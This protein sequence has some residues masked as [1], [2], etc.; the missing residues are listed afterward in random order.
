MRSALRLSLCLL[1]AVPLAFAQ[2]A[3]KAPAKSAAKE[4]AE[5]TGR[6]VFGTIGVDRKPDGTAE[7]TALKG[8][9]LRLGEDGKHALAYDTELARVV[10]GWSG[11]FVTEMNL[12]SR[13]EYPSALGS[14]YFST[15]D[16]LA[17]LMVGE[18]AA[19]LSVRKGYGHLGAGHYR[20][21]NFQPKGDGVLTFAVPGSADR[22]TEAPRVVDS[23]EAQVIVRALSTETATG[24]T[25][26]LG[27]TKD[28]DRIG[29]RGP[30]RREA[31]DGWEVYRIP[32]GKQQVEVA[33]APVGA[34]RPTGWPEETGAKSYA[35]FSTKKVVVKG[36]LSTKAGEPYVTDRIKLPEDN[37][38]KAPMYVSGVDFFDDGRV[39]ICTFHGDVWIGSGLDA[40][41]EQVTWERF[42]TGLYHPL[43]LKVVQGVIHVT[44]R[45]GLWK[46]LPGASGQGSAQIYA[47][48]NSDVQVTKNFHEFVFDLQADAAGNLYFAKAGPVKKGGRGFDDLCDHHGSLFK[49]DA[50]G[51]SLSV[52]A[53]GFRAPNG[54]GLSPTGQL[55]SGDN[56]GTWTPVCRLNWIKQGGFYGV[57]PLAHRATEPTDYDRPLCW[58]PKDVDNSSGGQVWV[59]SEQ[60]GPWKGR[61]LHLSYGTCSLF[62][63][64][65]QEVSFRGQPQ[66]QGG[67]TR[68]NV[69]FDSGAMRARFNP[70]D[71]QLYVVGL[72]GWQTTAVRNGCLQRVRYTGEKV[73]TPIDLKVAQGRVELTFGEPLDAAVAKDLGSWNLEMWNYL[74][75]AAYG[76]PDV[77]TRQKSIG[78]VELGKNGA[79]EYSKEQMAQANHDLL[80]VARVELSAD[81]RT[82]ILHVAELAPCMQ[83][84]LKYNLRSADG[85]DLTGRVVNTIHALPAGQ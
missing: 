41:L 76:S 46:L 44:C 65:P 80:K 6:W 82:A 22:V 37:A 56:E 29:V 72:R 33:Y 54:L 83:M 71:G 21:A 1:L 64:L 42:A 62:G 19:K 70:K 27:R 69:N 18:N 10:G 7:H 68:F 4:P 81:G 36:E 57:P 11:K 84:S 74:W 26:L 50:T 5:A 47:V 73:R 51:Q 13:G 35:D 53:T 24:V 49:V 60:W 45:D 14:V 59:T 48:F 78:T 58:M 34:A 32:A 67:L 16:D 39:A 52:V 8:L 23:N 20:L 2:A 79:P 61:L 63:V 31:I 9:A 66:M 38:W 12:M 75:S 77:S 40:K 3:K 25:V 28:A 43:G 30:G 85:T 15:D 17:G 55:T